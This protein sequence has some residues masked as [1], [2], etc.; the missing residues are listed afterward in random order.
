MIEYTEQA[1][2]F[3]A[4]TGTECSIV[5]LYTGQYF[6]CDKESRDVYQFTLTNARGIYSARFGNSIYNTEARAL[7]EKY[8]SRAPIIGGWSSP[9][10]L[11][12]AAKYKAMIAQKAYLPPSAYHVLACLTKNDPG[13]FADFCADFGYD[14]D[15]IKAQKIY[16]A[17]QEEWNAIRRMFSNE[18]IDQLREIQ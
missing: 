11:K 10:E 16:F 17:V 7:F 3:L 4:D 18:Q 1:E 14:S 9:R 6:D 5:Y 13:T 8:G 15:S 12:E 2:Q